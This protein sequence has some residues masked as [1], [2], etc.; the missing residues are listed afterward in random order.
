MAI[1]PVPL[2]SALPAHTDG[3]QPGEPACTNGAHPPEP[4]PN[5][6][7]RALQAR[8][9]GAKSKGPVTPEGKARSA[10]NARRHGLCAEGPVDEAGRAAL[11]ALEAGL[12]AEWRPGSELDR[13]LVGQMASALWRL[14]RADAMEAEL[15]TRGL[16]VPGPEGDTHITGVELFL[17]PAGQR[18][19]ALLLRYRG[20]AERQLRRAQRM[21]EDR[22]PADP[23]N[24]F[25]AQLPDML[26]AFDRMDAVRAGAAERTERTEQTEAFPPLNRRERRRLAALERHSV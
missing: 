18:A 5:A 11:A 7:H 16:A 4:A 2:S 23:S 20:A 12:E 17:D 13:A 14:G 1:E 24:A 25:A 19:L 22:R 8:I 10:Q 15:L 9:N 6:T 21:L 26:R 3:A